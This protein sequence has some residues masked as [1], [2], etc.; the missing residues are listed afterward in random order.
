MSKKGKAQ[1]TFGTKEYDEQWGRP[2]WEDSDEMSEN[3]DLD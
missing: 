1:Y 3:S 2:E